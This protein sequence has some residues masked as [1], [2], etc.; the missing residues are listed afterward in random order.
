MCGN[1]RP[2]FEVCGPC[3]PFRRW[4]GTP[5]TGP[6]IDP[7]A[8]NDKLGVLK[9]ASYRRITRLSGGHQAIENDVQH[10]P[11]PASVVPSHNG[12][13]PRSRVK[14]LKDRAVMHRRGTPHASWKAF[15][16]Y[17]LAV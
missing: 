9:V 1:L 6:P 17:S 14:R 2:L 15:V 8:R 3:T 4:S 7:L 12:A 13:G 5:W 11:C 10:G 16:Q